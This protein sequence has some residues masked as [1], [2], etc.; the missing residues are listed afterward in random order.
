[1]YRIV[2][3]IQKSYFCHSTILGVDRPRIIIAVQPRV[4]A[5]VNT[6]M[7]GGPNISTAI[8]CDIRFSYSPAHETIPAA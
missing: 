4:I 8:I 2:K 7:Q 3:M 1:M 5:Q 6:A